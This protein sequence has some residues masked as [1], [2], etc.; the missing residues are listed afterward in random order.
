MSELPITIKQKKLKPYKPPKRT[1]SFEFSKMKGRSILKIHTAVSNEG[2]MSNLNLSPSNCTKFR[3]IST[4][5]FKNCLPR[6]QQL[7]TTQH[8]LPQ[9]NPNKEKLMQDLGRSISFKKLSKRRSLIQPRD[10]P[11]IYNI[12]FDSKEKP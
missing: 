2:Q 12:R 6:K 3:R 9:Y 7:F 8:F 4:P 1:S 5:Q 10:T 11:E